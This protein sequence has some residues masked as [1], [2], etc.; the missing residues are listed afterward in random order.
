MVDFLNKMSLPFPTVY[1]DIMKQHLKTPQPGL[2]PKTLRIPAVL[3][4]AI[5]ITT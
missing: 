5:K 1:L 3:Q 4:Q 2:E